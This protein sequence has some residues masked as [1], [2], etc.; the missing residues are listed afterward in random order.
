M[1]NRIFTAIKSTLGE[2]FSLKG[3]VESQEQVEDE[4]RQG[5]SF[6]GTNAFILIFAILV[7]SLGLNTNSTAVI[8]GAMLISPLMGPIIGIGL[9]V[10]IQD[11]PLLR[12][13]MRNLAV[14][15]GI[16]IIASTAFFL[17]SP[18][19]E[20]HSELLARTSPTIYDV[21]IAF[22]GGAAGII[23]M[24]S[25]AKGN[26]IPGVAIATALMPP[27][28]T[29]G[30]GLATL[31][32]HYFFG[33]AYLFLINSIF[34]ALATFLGVKI[35]KFDTVKS[36]NPVRARKVRTYVYVIAILTLLPSI[37][38]TYNMI[39]QNTLRLNAG[40]FVSLE[41]QFPGTQVLSQKII[42]TGTH[43]QLDVTLLG[44]ILPEDSLRMA[45]TPRM[46]CYG[47]KDI[48]LNIIQGGAA[49]VA[50]TTENTSISQVYNAAQSAIMSQQAKIDSL[51]T[52]LAGVARRD[53]IGA[54]MAPE[55]KVV[56]P[57][58]ENISVSRN[59]FCDVRNGKLDTTE[60]A[61]VHFSRYI[62]AP[63]R[64]RLQ[65]YLR[66]R[67]SSKRVRLIEI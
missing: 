9:G 54:A 53:T 16:S 37:Y 50:A 22:F 52:Q 51:Q 26:V 8:I 65:Q 56:F 44:R 45:L 64:E 14:A 17:I 6:R 38:L 23:G 39:R 29:A 46:A 33:A 67:L 28:C 5:I 11:F 15:A 27:L 12:L 36:N 30:Y 48:S 43:R 49:T 60:V 31:Q 40:R 18:V 7:A 41:M 59:V 10:G 47:L 42:G 25:R 21:L 35:L 63:D 3:Y 20:G 66:A 55:L 58:V 34:I 32:L 62:S 2:Y 57:Q 24:S 61:L 13:S 1:A 19:A 4:I